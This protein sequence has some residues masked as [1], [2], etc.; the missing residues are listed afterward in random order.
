VG[1]AWRVVKVGKIVGVFCIHKWED[2][3]LWFFTVL[4]FW[5]FVFTDR[6][7]VLCF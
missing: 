7:R 3:R 5:C 2:W 6:R 4:L 1:S